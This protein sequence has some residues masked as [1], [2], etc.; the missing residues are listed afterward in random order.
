MIAIIAFAR[1]Q[2]ERLNQDARR[3]RTTPRPTTYKPLVPSTPSRPSLPKK[4]TGEELRD[5]S[6]KDLWFYQLVSEQRFS[7]PSLLPFIIHTVI[8]IVVITVASATLLQSSFLQLSSAKKKDKRERQKK[9]EEKEGPQPHAFFLPCYCRQPTS[10]FP[11]LLFSAA[12]ATTKR[13]PA[14]TVAPAPAA[15][16]PSSSPLLS[17]RPPSPSPPQ[18]QPQPHPSSHTL[19][20]RCSTLAQ[21]PSSSTA[22]SLPRRCPTAPL[23]SLSQQLPTPAIL[24]C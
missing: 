20:G 21:P 22:L 24:N 7:T 1:I 13:S 18:P 9:K 15:G 5:R 14:A 8:A 2:E 23:P 4:L 17:R 12:P 11:L 10:T 3:M 16:Q 6:A 19:L